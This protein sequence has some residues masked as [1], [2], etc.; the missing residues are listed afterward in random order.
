LC[1]AEKGRIRNKMNFKY[2]A[3]LYLILRQSANFAHMPPCSLIHPGEGKLTG[4]V[5][6]KL[7]AP[8]SHR[9]LLMVS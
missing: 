8:G 9:C 3:L 1:A 4:S 7:T 2:C 6:R 5:E